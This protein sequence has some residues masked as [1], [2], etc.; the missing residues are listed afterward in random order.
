MDPPAGAR[1]GE[2]LLSTVTDKTVNPVIIRNATTATP[3]SAVTVS[4]PV[5]DTES[6]SVVLSSSSGPSAD[7]GTLADPLGGGSFAA[8]SR[9]FNASALVTGTPTAATQILNRLVYTPPKLADG[10]SLDVTA[11][12]TV[13]DSFSFSGRYPPPTRVRL[14]TVTAPA[15]TG[16]VANAPVAS[17]ATLRPFGSVQVADANFGHGAKTAATIVLTDGGALTDADGLLTGVGLSKTGVG[18]YAVLEGSPYSLQS[19]L[20]G[21]VFTPTAVGPGGSRTTAFELIV[22]DAAAGLSADNKNTSVAVIGPA[23]VAPFIA[24]T[25]GTQTVAPGNALNPFNGV[26]IS[27]ATATALDTAT[28]TVT[29]GGTLGGAG[30]TATAPGIYSIAAT[31]PASLTAVLNKITFTPPPLAG[32]NSITSTIRLD[33]TNGSQTATD[34]ATAIQE[35]APPAATQTASGASFRISDQTTGQ[36]TPVA[37]DPYAG[38][39][40]GLDRQLVLITPDN[41]NITA[42]VPNVF[43][44]SGVGIDAIDVSKV[45]GNNVLDGSTNSNFLIGGAGNDTFFVDDRLAAA[46]FWSTVVNF[47]AGDAATAFGVTPSGF[48]LDWQDN[49]GAV[50]AT[51][52][53]LH[54]TAANKPTASL[55]L[56]G[57]SKADLGNGRLTTLFGNDGAGSSYLYIKGN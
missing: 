17:G 27:D 26:T 38:Q 20:Q 28:L 23:S 44:H 30:L 48:T 49:Q 2:T 57:Y 31:S 6:I 25:S 35:I 9:A 56:A 8:G 53:T 46:D 43:I 32:Q 37:G 21:L 33:V 7:L 42:L 40:P 51:G 19:Y 39:V 11:D 16:T 36:Q 15:V 13:S 52:L 45:S 55:T 54:I 14:E 22:S 10:T 3:F 41:L 5:G 4:D 1:P 29:G 12:I 18:T 24:G 34:S 50:G 47:H